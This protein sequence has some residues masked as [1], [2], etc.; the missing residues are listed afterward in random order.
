MPNMNVRR[1][2]ESIGSDLQKVATHVAQYSGIDEREAR[3]ID[4]LATD[5]AVVAANLAAEA[6][7]K[8][9]DRS[10]SGL[11]AKIRKALGFTYR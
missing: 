4:N 3:A 1:R 10:A 11:V 2:L 7:I 9:G 6:R 8:M 5:I